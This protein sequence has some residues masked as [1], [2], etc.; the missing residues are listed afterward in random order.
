MLVW[1]YIAWIVWPGCCSWRFHFSFS[2]RRASSGFTGLPSSSRGIMRPWNGH[3]NYITYHFSTLFSRCPARTL[4]LFWPLLYLDVHTKIHL[5]LVLCTCAPQVWIS[6][7][8]WCISTSSLQKAPRFPLLLPPREE[9]RTGAV[10]CAWK[11]VKIQILRKEKPLITSSCRNS[12]HN[13]HF[14]HD[15]HWSQWL[16]QPV[17]WW[18]PDISRFFMTL[19]CTHTSCIMMPN[20]KSPD[21]CFHQLI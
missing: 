16:F 9:P 7:R 15:C 11:P 21:Q 14:L 10:M 6:Q 12:L 17:K 5:A 18:F 3:W 19:Y 8:M 1:L 2:N 4:L 13:V 20:S